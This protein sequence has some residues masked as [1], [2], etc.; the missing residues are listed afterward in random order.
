VRIFGAVLAAAAIAAGSPVANAAT[1]PTGTAIAV[2]QSSEASGITGRRLLAPEGPVYSGDRV[3]T[4]NV[5]QAQL[6]FRDSTRL[7]VGPN[8]SLVLD[9][10]VFNDDNSAKAISLN[11]VKGAFRFITGTGPKDAYTINTPTATISVRG[12]AFDLNV[13]AAGITRAAVFEGGIITCDKLPPPRRTCVFQ[14]AS[15]CELIIVETGVPPRAVTSAAE[16]ARLLL[17]YFPFVRSQAT[18]LIDFRLAIDA[19]GQVQTGPNLPLTATEGVQP[20]AVVVPDLPDPPRP[21]GPPDDLGGHHCGGNCGVGLGNGGGNGTGNEGNGKGP[22]EDRGGG[23]PA[24]HPGNGKG[25][26]S[27]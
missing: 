2:V 16:R 4:G 19:C 12:T 17:T 18:L 22:P 8:S 1:S 10:F 26:N 21:P 23:R 14:T 5:G 15:A 3:T 9:G 27:D 25:K 24:E 7:V 6:R 20:A 13:D 11:A